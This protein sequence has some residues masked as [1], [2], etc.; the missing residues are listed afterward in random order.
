MKVGIALPVRN[1]LP[2]V[3]TALTTIHAQTY[4]ASVYICEDASDD[5]TTR[6]LRDRPTWYRKMAR[7]GG[8]P[9]GW[10][11]SLNDAALLAI[12]DGC[13]AVFVMNAD[14]FLR[15]DC[16][17]K[18]VRA[19]QR[20]DA[21]VPWTQQVGGENVVQASAE[22]L[23]AHNLRDSTPLVAF[24]LVR[25]KVWQDLGG[26][27]ED[28]NLPGLNAGYNEWDFWIRF[29][30]FRYQHELVREPVVYYRVHEA[31]LS[32]F[33]TERHAEA[34]GLL[35]AKHPYLFGSV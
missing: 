22:T 7:H 33:T 16:I 17:E 24:T 34:K 30:K 6:F 18:C 8:E 14:D 2:Y 28:V 15:L 35:A 5:G 32:R 26:Y 31:Q 1:A 19:L 10:P 9:L 29:N 12:E 13:D 3:E 23:G 11:R 21:V 27:A 20:A 25:S 4:P